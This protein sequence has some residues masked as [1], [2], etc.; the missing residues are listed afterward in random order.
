M[1]SAGILLVVMTLPLRELVEGVSLSGRADMGPSS[2]GA[3]H[4]AEI[5]DHRELRGLLAR[6]PAISCVCL[7]K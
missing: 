5:V 2:G 1:H 4:T 3:A 7:R 6:F